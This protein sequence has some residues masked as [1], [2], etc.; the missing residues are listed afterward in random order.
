MYFKIFLEK[1][2]YSNLSVEGRSCFGSSSFS[3]PILDA[4]GSTEYFLGVRGEH[5]FKHLG[6]GV[7]NFPPIPTC[8]HMYCVYHKYVLYIII[9]ASGS[10]SF[11]FPFFPTLSQTV[12]F[13]AQ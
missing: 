11:I 8:P 7:C 3:I 4:P 6:G 5:F 10:C 13:S 9:F 2:S 1:I 12:S